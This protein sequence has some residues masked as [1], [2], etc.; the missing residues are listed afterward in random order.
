MF[1]IFLDVLI[2]LR[3]DFLYALTKRVERI[4]ELLDRRDFTRS[5]LFES[6][7]T[8]HLK[9]QPLDSQRLLE[10]CV[11]SAKSTVVRLHQQ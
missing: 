9:Q 3:G 1:D 4:Y 8:K 11:S 10:I 7:D 6:M 2:E 5:Y